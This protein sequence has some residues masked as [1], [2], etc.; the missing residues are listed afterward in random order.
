MTETWLRTHIFSQAKNISGYLK[1]HDFPFF[2]QISDL[3]GICIF[4]L[5]ALDS[6]RSCPLNG[7]FKL[8]FQMNIFHKLHGILS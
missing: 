2:E 7:T 3:W 4:D 1:I 6:M 8:C 5:E